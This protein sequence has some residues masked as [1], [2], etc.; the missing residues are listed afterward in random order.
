MVIVRK[1]EALE[2]TNLEAFDVEAVR[3]DGGLIK[4]I[5]ERKGKMKIG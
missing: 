5:K 1:S 3:S 2:R 4:G